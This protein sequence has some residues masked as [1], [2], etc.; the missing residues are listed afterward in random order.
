MDLVILAGHGL[1]GLLER[2]RPLLE[3]ATVAL[4]GHRPAELHSDLARGNAHLDLAIR[5]L[6]APEVRER[7]AARVGTDAAARLAERP[8]WLHLDYP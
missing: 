5:A 6:T 8:A 2:D 3:P 1:P 7:G 4:L